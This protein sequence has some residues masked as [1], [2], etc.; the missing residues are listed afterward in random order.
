LHLVVKKLYCSA[1]EEQWNH[2]CNEKKKSRLKSLAA[3]LQWMGVINTIV[4]SYGG[5]E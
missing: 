5:K 3:N 1:Y 2:L 4:C